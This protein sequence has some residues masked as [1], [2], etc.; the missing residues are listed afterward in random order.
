MAS[1][2]HPKCLT[3]YGIHLSP[4][5]LVKNDENT[6]PKSLKI[7]VLEVLGCPGGSWGVSWDQ[8][9]LQDGKTWENSGSLDPPPQPGSPKLVKNRHD[10]VPEGLL[11]DKS[12]HLE[13]FLSILV[14]DVFF[15]A[16]Q[17]EKYWF[18]RQT[19]KKACIYCACLLFFIFHENSIF[20]DLW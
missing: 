12:H 8:P 9:G 1:M 7:V 10:D 14:W 6:D 4:K 15:K 13:C 17:I 16:F 3:P 5:K 2:W 20:I 18:L 11:S 19:I